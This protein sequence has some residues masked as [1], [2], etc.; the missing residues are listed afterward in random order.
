[1]STNI[2]WTKVQLKNGEVYEGDTWNPCV[3]GCSKQSAGCMNCYAIR[4]AWRLMHSPHAKIRDKYAGSVIKTAGGQLNWSGQVKVVVDDTLT[5]PL[6]KKRPTCYFVDSMFDLFHEDVPIEIIEKIFAVMFLAK[7]HL[8]QIL[9]KNPWRMWNYLTDISFMGRHKNLHAVASEIG[10][11]LNIRCP[12]TLSWPLPNLWIGASIE[13][14]RV[15]PRLEPLLLSPAAFRFISYEPALGPLYFKNAWRDL[16]ESLRTKPVLSGIHQ[17]I[18]GAESGH[19]A[20]PMELDWAIDVKNQCKEA[21]VAF[22]MKQIVVNKHKIPFEE[23][24][25]ELQV[26]EYPV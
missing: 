17:I 10:S 7:N 12:E 4:M 20:R 9:T 13:D 3:V 24:P 6:S 22:F 2:E 5:E 11:K 15:M 8:F 21:G 19:G 16:P 18:A 14:M 26:R 1:M 23:F 25:E